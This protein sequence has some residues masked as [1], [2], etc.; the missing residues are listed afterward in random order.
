ME[1]NT[2]LTALSSGKVDLII[3]GLDITDERKQQ[4]DFTQGYYDNE[5]SLVVV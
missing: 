2:L 4:V 5:L 3:S 1:F